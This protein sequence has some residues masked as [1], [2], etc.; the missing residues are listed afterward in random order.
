MLRNPWPKTRGSQAE[1]CEKLDKRSRYTI[2]VLLAVV[3]CVP[4]QAAVRLTHFMYAGHA[5]KW[6]E[7]LEVMASRFKA[8]T[9]VDVEVVVSTGG[10]GD[11]QTKIQVMIT[12]G[13]PPDIH[14]RPSGDRSSLDRPR[15]L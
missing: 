6:Q 14:R 9:G 8:S 13:T 1:G 12:G 2:V 5:A 10:S 7:Y 15:Y 11:R 3:L 4:T